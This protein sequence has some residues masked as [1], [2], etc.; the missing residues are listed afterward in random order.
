MDLI[1]STIPFNRNLS[2]KIHIMP[3]L[4]SRPVFDEHVGGFAEIIQILSVGDPGFA[5]LGM[6]AESVRYGNP[7]VFA[8]AWLIPSQAVCDAARGGFPPPIGV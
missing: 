3:G 5:G 6:H 1:G 4:S 8:S 7:G 2:K